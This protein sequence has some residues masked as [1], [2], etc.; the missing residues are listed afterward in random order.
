M[1]TETL[2]QFTNDLFAKLKDFDQFKIHQLGG[3]KMIDTIGIDDSNV[4]SKQL[5]QQIN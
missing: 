4:L 3:A 2:P 5:L 1:P